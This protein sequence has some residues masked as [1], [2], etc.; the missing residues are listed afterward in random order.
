MSVK[1][2]TKK[3]LKPAIYNYLKRK[4]GKINT[5]QPLDFI[6]PEQRRIRSIIGGLETSL[7]T[8]LWENLAKELA[9]KNGFKVND[10]KKLNAS[11]AIIPDNLRL[12]ISDL[13][14][15]KFNDNDLS[16]DDIHKSISEFI[17]RNLTN[18]NFEYGTIPKGEGVDIWFEKNGTEYLYDIKTVQI[19]AGSG[20]KFMHTLINWH[21]YRALSGT[22]KE[23][24]TGI[25]FPFNP[26][27]PKDFWLKEKGKV[28]PMT[29][30]VDAF[31]A[32]EFWDFIS[33]EKDST[34]Q[35]F[36]AFRELGGDKDLTSFF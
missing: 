8:K 27:A 21:A 10:V 30:S 22:Q 13:E 34:E 2:T 32:D 18:H 17:S 7:G 33:G 20:P 14:Y 1:D 4:G 35:I 5:V 15:Q 19:N 31:V 26:H 28:S 6:F 12:H 36:D 29:P 16:L 25:A 11:V 3:L 24:K 23:I 9:L